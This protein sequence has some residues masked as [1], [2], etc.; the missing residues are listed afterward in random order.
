MV[1]NSSGKVLV[2]GEAALTSTSLS[3]SLQVAASSDAD[4]IAIIGRAADDI[5]EISFYEADKSTNLGEIQ[6]RTT[7]TNIRARSAGAEINFA[8]TTSGGSMGDRLTITADGDMGLGTGG[9]TVT[10]RL[11]V[12]ESNTTVFNPA[13]NLPTIARLYN[14]SATNG[15][16]A[17]LQLRTD[18]NNGAAGMQ[19]IHA[20]NSSTNYDS[21]LVFSRRLATSGSYAEQLRIKNNGQLNLGGGLGG[22]NTRNF[23]TLFD[24]HPICNPAGAL[25]NYNNSNIYLSQ[26]VYFTGQWQL[27]QAAA[28]SY[29]SQGGGGFSFLSA[30]SGSAGAATSLY[31]L[32][33]FEPNNLSTSLST[34]NR[35]SIK[36]NLVLFGDSSA[37]TNGGIEFHTSGGGGGGYGSKITATTEGTL[38]I[39]TRNNSSAWST[40]FTVS[41]TASEAQASNFGTGG[42]YRSSGPG[43]G[44]GIKLQGLAAGSGS[45]AVDT[46][47]SVNQGNASATMLVIGSRNTSDQQHVQGY[48]WLLR[49]AYNGDHLP[50]IHPITGNSSFWSISKS[51]SNTLQINGNSGNWQFGGI[52]VT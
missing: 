22:T 3:H 19:Y 34:S 11:D 25:F 26:N 10:Q 18:N 8:T 41:G 35:P 36:G 13:S 17:G 42:Y 12:R 37:S 24:M 39:H 1:I 15:A 2:S 43:G 32:V 52:W 7:E 30:P 31:K 21:D 51:G 44:S 40:K 16:S 45:N 6:Y 48:A 33:G 49:F 14:T 46:G 23:T 9:N 47:I 27:D 29:M 20:V 5:G 28:G 38:Q 50:A 4:G